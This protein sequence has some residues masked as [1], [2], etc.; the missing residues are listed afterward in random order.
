[1]FGLTGAGLEELTAALDAA[2]DELP[3]KRDIGRPRLPIDRV[4]TIGG[5]GTVVTG[6]LIDGSLRVGDEIEVT[7]GG[8]RGRIRGLQSHRAAVERA[9]PG[10][11][12]AVNVSG[13][14]KESLRRGMVI[15]APGRLRPTVVVD[16]RV[17]AVSGMPR[18]LKHNARLSFHA[19]AD[20]ANA[21]LRLLDM[22]ELCV[23]ETAWAQ[24]KLEA[25]MSVVRGDHFVLRT[26]EDTVAGGVIADIAPKRH[27]R[28][29]AGVV[30]ALEAMLRDTPE[31]LVRDA[32][33]RHPLLTRGM[34]DDAVPLPPAAISAAIDVLADA[35][36]IRGLHADEAVRYALVEH[37]N[38]LQAEALTALAAYHAEHRLRAGMPRQ[39]LRS[40]LGID[41]DA[42]GAVVASWDGIRVYEGVA[43]LASFVSRPTPEEQRA[44]D[45]Y[46]AALSDAAGET[47]SP[48]LM[49]W[50]AQSGAIVDAGSGV[51]FEARAF[52]AMTS[53]VRA[54][55][56]EHGNITIA[57]ARDLFGTNRKR[58]Q[59]LLEELD[60][61]HVT[62]RDGDAHVLW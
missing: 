57:E 40:R 23:G 60:R 49:S 16:A 54:H 32:I 24:I 43:A 6:T 4:F 2:I 31:D 33:A 47:L 10:T 28:H 19:G 45:A 3:P 26:P 41:A 44:V 29:D 48:A 61:R 7:P 46:L 21:L 35:G 13:I 34:L 8:M 42:F 22:D 55:I 38:A 18:G 5:F 20:E 27:R 1:M 58:A 52:D 59:A 37:V 25:P 12:T 9:L 53:S 39:E 56:T 15:A 62:R 14:A 11:R 51:V 17:R 36:V 50:L 30:A